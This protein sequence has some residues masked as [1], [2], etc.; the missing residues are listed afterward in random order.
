MA[1]LIAALISVPTTHHHTLGSKHVKELQEAL[2]KVDE[3]ASEMSKILE[4]KLREDRRKP[5][6]Q[7]GIRA[8]D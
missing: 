8:V 3:K 4:D 2:R 6:P 5:E 7:V 1:A